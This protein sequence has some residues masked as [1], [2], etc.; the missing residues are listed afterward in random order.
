MALAARPMEERPPTRHDLMQPSFLVVRFSA[1]GDCVM[2]SYVATAIRTRHL[3]CRLVWAVESRCMAVLDRSKMLTQ[4][5][6]FPRDQWRKRRW[7]PEVWRAQLARFARLR[8]M[9]FDFGLDLQGHS[10]TAICL[11]I[12]APKQRIAAFST[13]K[14]ARRLNPL[15]PG[16]P[17]GSHRVERMMATLRTYG[18]FDCPARPM[19][20]K[21]LAA[22]ELGLPDAKIATISTGAG[23]VIKQYPAEQWIRVANELT[24]RSYQVVFL[25]A[26]SDPRIELPGTINQIGKWTLQQTMSAVACS[27]VHLAADTGTGHMAAAYGVPFVSV[28]GSTDPKLYRPYSNN[29]KVLRASASPADVDPVDIV[30]SVEELVG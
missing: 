18:E 11:R 29:G 5:V 19:M 8:K 21:P 30:S 13:D 20:P 16:D 15:A 7:S 23:A 6:D 24:E 14:L 3:E 10:K 1:I 22:G 9:R 17:D 27:Q 28:F 26:A 25:G 4:V 2:A 12:A